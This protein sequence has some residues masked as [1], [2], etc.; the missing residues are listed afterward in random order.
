MTFVKISARASILALVCSF[1]PIAARAAV[2]QPLPKSL[3]F[4]ALSETMPTAIAPTAFAAEDFALEWEGTPL[5]GAEV[6]LEP[7]SL[8]WVRVADVLV[9]P[10]ARAL[11][12][13]ARAKR[14]SVKQADFTQPMIADEGGGISAELPVALITGTEIV[15]EADGASATLRVRFRP[16]PGTERG[17]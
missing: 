1:I 17:P 4:E 5:A 11:V 12:K 3:A 2:V 16:R 9:L 15:V 14:G 13:V 7:R 8:E 6:S 10:R